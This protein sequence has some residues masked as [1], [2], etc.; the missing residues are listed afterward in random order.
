MT[1]ILVDCFRRNRRVW[2]LTLTGCRLI[3]AA[4]V[5]TTIYRRF[6]PEM[7]DP[8]LRFDT[9]IQKNRVRTDL[10]VFYSAELERDMMDEE[11][12]I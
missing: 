4:G 12:P 6:K 1:R 7:R 11:V 10:F 3:T 9:I 2:N 5:P 8:L